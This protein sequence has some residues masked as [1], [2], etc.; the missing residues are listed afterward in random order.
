LGYGGIPEGGGEEI[1][2]IAGIAKN[3]DENRTLPQINAD[4]R[5][6]G[7]E[8]IGLMTGRG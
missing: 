3:D 5:R 1:A 4:I 8:S 2:K 6:S 7:M